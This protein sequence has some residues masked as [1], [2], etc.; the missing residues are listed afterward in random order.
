MLTIAYLPKDYSRHESKIVFGLSLKKLLILFTFGA[1]A[2]LILRTSFLNLVLKIILL[3][4][5]IVLAPIVT[6]YKTLEGDDLI[7]YIFNL[8]I[9]YSSP[10]YLVYK[11]E[12]SQEGGEKDGKKV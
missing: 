3:L 5:L 7:T 4:V 12:H 8:L 11:K 9:Y 10:R 2:I 1:L 6:F